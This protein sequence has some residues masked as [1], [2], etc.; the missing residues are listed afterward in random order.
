LQNVFGGSA[1]GPIPK[2]GGFWFFNYQ[3]VRRAQWY[4]SEWVEH[5][6]NCAAASVSADGSS[7]CYR[8]G[9]QVRSDSAQIDPVAV[10]ILNLQDNR[11]GGQYL[12]LVLVRGLRQHCEPTAALAARNF[13]CSFSSVAPIRDNQ[14]TISYDRSFRDDKDKITG[15]WFW[16]E[17]SVAKPFGPTRL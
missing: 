9:Y 1:S 2:A 5:V 12:V 16:D 8:P 15:T 6:T 3:G 13:N 10:K 17:G 7:E 11:F 4:R 14:Y